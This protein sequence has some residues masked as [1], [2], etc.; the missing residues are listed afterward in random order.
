[1]SLFLPPSIGKGRKFFIRV[2]NAG[3]QWSG[4]RMRDTRKRAAVSH[5]SSCGECEAWRVDRGATVEERVS[6]NRG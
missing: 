5:S 6:A 4:G 1:M 2:W 3:A